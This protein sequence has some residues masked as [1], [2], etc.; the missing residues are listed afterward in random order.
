MTEEVWKDI[1][2]FN[3]LYKGYY[4]ISNLGRVRSLDRTDSAGRKLSGRLLKQSNNR[5]GYLFVN[6]SINGKR[7]TL[8]VNRLVAKAFIPNPY[9]KIF[10]NHKDEDKHNNNVNNLE[11]VTPKENS[12]CGTSIERSAKNRQ[13]R[14]KVIYRDNTY[15][16]WES[17]TTFAQ[18]YRNGVDQRHI[19]DVLKGRRK[20]HRGLRF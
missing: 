6:I 9:D 11:W 1:L 4:Q 2:D 18:E 13:K 17:A 14:I 3:G 5:V 15:E 20:K 19:V 12:N 10:V 8:R 16:Y 7:K